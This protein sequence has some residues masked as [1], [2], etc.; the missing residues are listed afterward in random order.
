M[1]QEPGLTPA[2]Q[3]MEAIMGQLQPSVQTLDREMLIFAAGRAAQGSKRPWQVTCGVLTALLCGS[4]I[5]H[6]PL[7]RPVPSVTVVQQ[8]PALVSP[9]EMQPA[10]HSLAYLNLQ[11][12][13]FSRGLDALPPHRPVRSA[14]QKRLDQEP[15]LKESLSSHDVYS[16]LL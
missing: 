2:Q 1:C 7:T 11:K 13:V 10:D 3:K 6:V 9:V 15:L 12:T 8:V 14:R 4:L 5:M 16:G